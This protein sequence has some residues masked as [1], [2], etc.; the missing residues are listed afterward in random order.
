MEKN[1]N[2]I[3][4]VIIKHSKKK[5]NI[6]IFSGILNFV[7]GRHVHVNKLAL[8]FKCWPVEKSAKSRQS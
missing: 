1:N 6:L 2:Y 3:M 7:L 5:C 8:T 4:G